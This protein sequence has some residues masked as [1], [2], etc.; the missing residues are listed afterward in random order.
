MLALYPLIDKKMCHP[1]TVV[2]F[3]AICVEIYRHFECM[4][5][6]FVYCSN[7]CLTRR[8]VNIDI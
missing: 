5:Q 7:L 8:L 3:E 2:Y 1:Q 6:V 4:P